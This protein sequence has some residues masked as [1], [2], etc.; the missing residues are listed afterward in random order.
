MHHEDIIIDIIA[1]LLFDEHEISVLDLRF[2]AIPFRSHEE[3]VVDILGSHHGHSDGDFLL[4]IFLDNA[5]PLI[6]AL[7]ESVDRELDDIVII[8]RD[9][10][11]DQ[12][13]SLVIFD[14]VSF[15]DQ[16]VELVQYGL[17]VASTY[18]MCNLSQRDALL[19]R[20]LLE[21][22]YEG[23]LDVVEFFHE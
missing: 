19:V 9:V 4:G 12:S 3:A 21:E 6:S 18:V 5:L 16:L 14:K 2:H 11:S 23:F 10:L 15:Q 13:V 20:V 8:V 22:S 17:W 1:W 7:S